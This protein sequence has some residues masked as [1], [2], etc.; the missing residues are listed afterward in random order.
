LVRSAQEYV[1]GYRLLNLIMSGQTSQVWEAHS[2]VKQQRVAIKMLLR[3]FRKDREHIAYLKNEYAAG[4]KLDSPRVIHIFE[5]GSHEGSPY[6]AMEYFPFPNLKQYLNRGADRLAYFVPKIIQQAA[7]G[8]DYFNQQGWIHRDVKPDNFL[9]DFE[10]DVKLIDF[11]LAQKKKTGLA[12]L[13]GGGGKK[14]QGT[15][16]YMSPEQIRAQVLD[17]RADLYSFGCVLHELVGG[18]PPFTGTSSNE[19]LGKHLK[20]PPPRLDAINKNVQAGFAD[21]VLRMLAKDPAKRPESVGEFLQEFRTLRV[22]K[23]PP[24]SPSEPP[25]AEA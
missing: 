19:L 9:M 15:R 17:Q 16:S 4:C 8:L 2:D 11:A 10:G 22:Y 3:D 7:E 14:V 5:I 23:I 24:K 25:A 12:R 21:L 13:F 18:K 1:G 20:S 6:L